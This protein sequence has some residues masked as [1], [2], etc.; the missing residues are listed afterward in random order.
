MPIFYNGKE[1]V[2]FSHIPKTA[3]SSLYVW[4]AENGWIVTNLKLLHNVGTGVVFR[5]KFGI[6]QCQ[7]ERKLPSKVSPQ[8]STSD[9]T[10]EW[11][12][13]SSKFCVVRHPLTR[14]VSELNY[15]F[16]EYCK[17]GNIK[18]IDDEVISKYV[19]FFVKKIMFEE[20]GKDN[21]VRDNHLRPQV[22]FI[23]KDMNVLYLE[24]DWRKW[25]KRK[26]RLSGEAKSYNE[27][28]RKIELEKHICENVRG[29]V[30][31]FYRKDLDVL[32]YPDDPKSIYA[33]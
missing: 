29:A 17:G 15:C 33:T 28:I 1:R 23:N 2:L 22:D 19:D 31:D 25:L 9:I 10:S 20:Y 32:G 3:G 26:Y 13:F 24:G 11:G 14:F 27:S 5:E 21:A 16:P 18:K 6:W 4:F 8:H 30:L 7:L 12:E